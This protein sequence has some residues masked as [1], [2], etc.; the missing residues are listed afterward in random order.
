MN[1]LLE[2]VHT[3]ANVVI[4]A[5]AGIYQQALQKKQIPRLRSG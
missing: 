1:L 4:P 5:Q 2:L 3:C